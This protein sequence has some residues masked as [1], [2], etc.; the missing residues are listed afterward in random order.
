MCCGYRRALVAAGAGHHVIEESR[1]L[2]ICGEVIEERPYTWSKAGLPVR[3]LKAR[4]PQVTVSRGDV[5]QPLSTNAVRG[6]VAER[7]RQR[8]KCPLVAVS[9]LLEA[10]AFVGREV[11]AESRMFKS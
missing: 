2:G 11:N 7:C 9:A 6:I 1:K 4:S 10:S 3:T 5:P 8:S